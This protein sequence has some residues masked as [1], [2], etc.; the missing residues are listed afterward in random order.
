MKQIIIIIGV[1]LLIANLLFGLILSSYEAFNLFVSS[2]VIAITTILLL[3]VNIINL[4]DGFRISLYVLFSL[5]GI[6]EF[7]LS[8]FSFKAFENNWFLLLIVLFLAI[9]S[10]LLLVTY[11]ASIKIK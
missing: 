8:L 1:I 4:K 7:V 3:C 5:F 9:E 6:I 11:K 10:I 2:L